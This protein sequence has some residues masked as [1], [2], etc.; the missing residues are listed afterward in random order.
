MSVN[1]E[2]VLHFPYRLTTVAKK[3]TLFEKHARRVL[4]VPSK[5]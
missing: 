4:V 1:A 5:K 2:K 3:Q